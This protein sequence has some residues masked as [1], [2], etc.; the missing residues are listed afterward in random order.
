[1]FAVYFFRKR[2]WQSFFAGLLFAVYLLLLSYQLYHQLFLALYQTPPFFFNDLGLLKVGWAN[3]SH[4][5]GWRY[6]LYLLALLLIC[7]VLFVAVRQLVRGMYRINFSRISLGLMLFLLLE[8]VVIAFRWGYKSWPEH[9]PQFQV[10]AIAKNIRES[11]QA[12]RNMAQLDVEKLLAYHPYDTIDLPVKPNLFLL[13]VESYGRIMY[14][15]KAL[16]DDYEKYLPELEKDLHA[17]GWYSSW[18]LSKA[19]ER[20]FDSIAPP[21]PPAAFNFSM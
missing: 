8:S 14:D 3:F 6:G 19:I 15:E 7:G 16:R 11:A 12:R 10:A 17:K 18:V 1:M 21:P 4:D 9:V 5:F 20:T 2:H 13:F